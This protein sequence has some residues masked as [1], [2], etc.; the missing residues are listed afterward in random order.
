MKY[1]RTEDSLEI[2]KSRQ[3]ITIEDALR[4]FSTFCEDIKSESGILLEQQEVGALEEMIKKLRWMGR[5]VIRVYE[6]NKSRIQ[7]AASLERLKKISD[8][9]KCAEIEADQAEKLLISLRE[10][11]KDLNEKIKC[12][13]EAREEAIQLDAI[14]GQMENEL[15]RYRDTDL[16]ELQ[17]T[18]RN[19]SE[20]LLKYRKEYETWSERCREEEQVLHKQKSETEAVKKEIEEFRVRCREE[21]NSYQNTLEETVALKLQSQEEVK[22]IQEEIETAG[23]SV[24]DLRQEKLEKEMEVHALRE[25]VRKLQELQKK[26][27]EI[28]E[29]LQKSSDV[30]K[31]KYSQLL[32][33]SE[34]LQSETENMEDEIGKLETANKKLETLIRI[35]K[36]DFNRQKLEQDKLEGE[37]REIQE[38]IQRLEYYLGK[39]DIDELRNIL[40]Q[41]EEEKQKLEDVCR[42]MQKDIDAKDAE[43]ITMS[44]VLEEQK[45]KKQNQV[46]QLEEEKIKAQEEVQSLEKRMVLAEEEQRKA[47]SQKKN[48]RRKIQEAEE[49]QKSIMEWF[50]GVEAEKYSERLGNLKKQYE[51][52][53]EARIQLMEDMEDLGRNG[54]EETEKIRRYFQEEIYEISMRLNAYQKKYLTVVNSMKYIDVIKV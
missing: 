26:Q 27:E 23:K 52:L 47:E 20:Q 29:T 2:L 21:K 34:M 8:E 45:K 5:T 43:I 13:K 18:H 51:I 1:E 36:E 24:E 17:K 7:D 4:F 31:E 11:S 6:K 32:A 35:Q 44:E 42:D 9:L 30:L 25:E 41:K 22:K 39:T 46:W 33:E 19:L 48:I 12:E 54:L 50:E 15:L 3:Q 16:P 53:E 40:R 10:K 28:K 38:R 37:H 14:C 49:K